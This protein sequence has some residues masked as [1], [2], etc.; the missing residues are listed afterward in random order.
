MIRAG[1]AEVDID[2]WADGHPAD[3]VVEVEHTNYEGAKR[4]IYRDAGI[5]ELWEVATPRADRD[6]AIIDLQAAGGPELVEASGVVQGVRP[7]GIE[8]ALDV[9]REVGGYG[10]FIRGAEGGDPVAEALLDAVGVEGQD[11]GRRRRAA[12]GN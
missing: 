12:A 5:R 10:D 8:D 11:A 6:T 4:G 3:L 1:L 2:A 9:L 7:A